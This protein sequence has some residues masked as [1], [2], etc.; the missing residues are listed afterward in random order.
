[1]SRSSREKHGQFSA[2]VRDRAIPLVQEQAPQYSSREGGDHEDRAQLGCTKDFGAGCAKRSATPGPASGQRERM[3]SGGGLH[4]RRD[5][6]WFCL[7][8]PS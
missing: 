3:S 5:L 2:D 8:W 6:A 4:V 7:M 1:M